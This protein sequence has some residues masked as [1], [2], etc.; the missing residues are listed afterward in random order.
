[1]EIA[2]EL[3]SVFAD[4]EKKFL[5]D[6]LHMSMFV[7]AVAKKTVEIT[8]QQVS[9]LQPFVLASSTLVGDWVHKATHLQFPKDYEGDPFKALREETRQFARVWVLDAAFIKALG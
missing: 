7:A 3:L 5:K 1:M 4:L 8:Q 6:E 9:M 2:V